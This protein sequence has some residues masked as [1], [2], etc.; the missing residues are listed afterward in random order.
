VGDVLADQLFFMLRCGIDTLEL[1]PDVK[2]ET[3]QQALERF[4]HVYQS[5]SDARKPVWA[6]RG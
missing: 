3:A 2:P 6:L 4:A 5:A 1:H